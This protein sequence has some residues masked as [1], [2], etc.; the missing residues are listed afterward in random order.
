[1]TKARM[2][3]L[4]V[5]GGGLLLV[6]LIS[7]FGYAFKTVQHDLTAQRERF[8]FT[9]SD[10][11][12]S[13]SNYDSLPG[14]NRVAILAKGPS[15]LIFSGDFTGAPV[16]IRAERNGKRMQP[17][18]AHF[19]PSSG[20]SS[21]TFTFMSGGGKSQCRTYSLGWRSPTGQPVTMNFG[22]FGVVY[23][24]GKPNQQICE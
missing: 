4:A 19:D 22:G 17:G 7:T 1:M 20:T 3:L 6:L 18:I 14:L 9:R 13:S 12:T 5:I 21:F 15:T 8:V 23:D 11:T 24:R 10:A 2:T 16:D